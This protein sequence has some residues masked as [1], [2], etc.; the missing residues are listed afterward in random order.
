[1]NKTF[2]KN[3]VGFF[4]VALHLLAWYLCYKWIRPH[5]SYEEFR[6]TVLIIAPVITIYVLA[7]VKDVIRHQNNPQPAGRAT[8]T[9]A[10]LAI[11]YALAFGIA[12]LYQIYDFSESANMSANQLK[13]ALAL[14]EMIGGG[15]FGLL[16]DELFGKQEPANPAGAT[17]TGSPTPSA[18]STPAGPAPS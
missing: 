2:L 15:M 7:F 5:L 14:T 9:F 4:L 18:T 17:V 13:D 1:M 16:I 8:K 6:I 3:I 10:T 11:I 12:L